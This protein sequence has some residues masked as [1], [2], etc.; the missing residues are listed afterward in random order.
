MELYGGVFGEKVSIEKERENM[1]ITQLKVNNI[2]EPLG[3]ALS[4]LSFSYRIEEAKNADTYDKVKTRIKVS[5]CVQNGEKEIF[6]SG[7]VEGANNL[8]FAADIALKP[9]TRYKWTVSAETDRKEKAEESSSFETGKMGEPW[10]AKWISAESEAQCVVFSKTFSAANAENA[11]LYVCALGVYEVYINGAKVGNEFLAPGYHSYDLHLQ[12]FAY[13]VEKYIATGENRIDI[14]AADGWF[15]GRLG[16][17]NTAQLY[18]NRL[19]AIAELYCGGKLALITDKTWLAHS[20]AIKAASIY[21]GEMI[22]EADIAR[23]KAQS[24]AVAEKAP[25]N[26]GELI[27]RYSLPIVK[28]DVFSVQKR[29]KSKKGETIFDFA[30]NVTGW[31]EFVCE[32]KAGTAIRLTAGEILQDGCFYRENYRTAKAEFT[33]ISSGKKKRVCPH[34]T[35]FGFRYMKA[36]VKDGGEW[37]ALEES[38]GFS[39]F[40]AV[41]LRS[42]FQQ[43]GFIKTGS[44]KVNQL[45]Q[46]ALWSQKDN[47]LDVPT[48]CPQRD[49]RLGW[50]G[51]AQIFCNTACC[52]MDMTAFYRKW[53]FDMRAEMKLTNGATPNIVPRIKVGMVSEAGISPWADAAVIV[54]W[55]VYRHSGSKT[56]LRE[57]Y[58]GMKAWVDF[59]FEREKQRGNPYLITG[60]FHFGDW[61][62]LDGENGSPFGATDP[63]FVASAYYYEDAKI[64]FHSAKILGKSSDT[65]KYFDLSNAILSAI[66]E[67][68][69]DER[70]LCRI[71]TQTALSL[72]IAF[73]LS[74]AAK[75]EG[76][77]LC[78]LIKANSGALNTGFVGTAFL[79]SALARTGNE[80]TAYD[81]LLRE[82]Y[83]SWLYAVNLGATTIW[84]RWNSVLADGTINAEGMNSLNHYSY[85]AIVAFLYEDV[86]G[87]RADEAGFRSAVIAPK[88]DERLGFAHCVLETAAGRYE[89][90][91]KIEGGKASYRVRIPFGCTARFV[92]P[93]GEERELSAGEFS[94][95]SFS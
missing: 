71:Q 17:D 92:F 55:T 94:F 63:L 40:Q 34:F 61:L 59:V 47:F 13:D 3:F 37:R 64:L 10:N 35:F 38:D 58:E 29:I 86:C 32:A 50:T 52:N 49:E 90:E 45:F 23:N 80:K 87:I 30:Q 26:C 46:N 33:Y 65:L 48:D 62:A 27:D 4:P 73:D 21:D 8:D 51:D 12:A 70:G 18:G 83:P 1:K 54:P 56:F 9:R 95:S 68:Y 57:S 7:D 14:I 79:C 20:C 11:R 88:A 74:K 36:Q 76:E 81:L 5:E 44:E 22:D 60:G 24:F 16:F 89:S 72:S 6:D 93:N 91:W 84:E 78:E 77:R 19:Y 82:E 66:R 53:L 25:D 15:K 69:F 28:H 75:R 67:K 2:K 42:D 43:T 85:G 39:G 41:H 31:V